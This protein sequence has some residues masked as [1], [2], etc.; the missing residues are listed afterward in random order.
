M[1]TI[2]STEKEI[3]TIIPQTIQ[4]P[5]K[6]SWIL[7]LLFL[8][9]TIIYY[10]LAQPEL[11]LF[12][13]VATKQNQLAPRIFLFLFPAISFFM[14]ILHFFIFKILQRYSTILIKLF[15]GITIGL[16]ILLGF[17]LFRIILITM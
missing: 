2:N 14:N 8:V 13:T 6:T 11:P 4:G 15:V 3:S 7:F 16:Q 1:Q 10:F 5:I 12:Y 17:A 9:T